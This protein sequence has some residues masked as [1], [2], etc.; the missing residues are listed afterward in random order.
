MANPCISL[1]YDGNLQM[2]SWEHIELVLHIMPGG[3]CTNTFYLHVSLF[4]LLAVLLVPLSMRSILSLAAISISLVLV[5]AITVQR[6]GCS[7]PEGARENQAPSESLSDE[8]TARLVRR[9][10]DGSHQPSQDTHSHGRS[11][12]FGTHRAPDAQHPPAGPSASSP[13]HTLPDRDCPPW[14]DTAA[15]RPGSDNQVAQWAV[16][17]GKQT[18]TKA[19]RAKSAP[20]PVHPVHRMA[21]RHSCSANVV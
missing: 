13:V 4:T 3:G 20:G 9:M 8:V 11:Q 16:Q 17:V 5:D 2:S 21:C 1:T 15:C 12:Q 7:A 6:H 10:Q 18:S 19:L 14:A